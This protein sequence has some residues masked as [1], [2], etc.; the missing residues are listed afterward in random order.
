M[1]SLRSIYFLLATTYFF[2]DSSHLRR[3]DDSTNALGSLSEE[4]EMKSSHRRFHEK[5]R[6]QEKLAE[7]YYENQKKERDY[8]K[9]V[10]TD[11]LR[12]GANYPCLYGTNAIG[13][14]SWIS[15]EDGHKYGCGINVIKGVPIIYSFG[16]DQRQDFELTVLDLRPDAK[17]FVFELDTG[18]MVPVNQRVSSISYNNYGLGYPNSVQRND[19]GFVE[20][21]R[22]L[23]NL[24]ALMAMNGHSYIDVMKIDCEGCEWDFIEKEAEVLSRVGQLMIEVHSNVDDK[25]FNANAKNII[26]FIEKLEAHDLR[27]F[28]KEPNL[29]N[30]VGIRC[31]SEFSLIQREWY[32]WN[33]AKLNFTKI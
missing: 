15:I 11:V 33:H 8:N 32:N 6:H 22:N 31:C 21:A 25:V 17:I 9:P 26:S 10:N 30:P 18:L 28:H 1:H 19:A 27:L 3:L 24:S 13:M 20:H 4:D 23:R 7:L 29:S 16:S 5:V 12:V 2:V 14:N